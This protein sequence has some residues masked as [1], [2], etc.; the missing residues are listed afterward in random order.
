MTI[1]VAITFL[2]VVSQSFVNAAP[3]TIVEDSQPRATIIVA[4][5]DPRAPDAAKALQKYIEKMSRATLDIIEEGDEPSQKIGIYVGHTQRAAEEGID[6]PSWHD[7]SVR[8]DAFNEE[9]YI[10]KTKDTDIF[11]GGNSDG[12]YIGVQYGAYALLD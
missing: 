7:A 4:Q 2:A 8:D 12:P 1:I 5:E 6:I 3:L 10:L 11:V 9:A